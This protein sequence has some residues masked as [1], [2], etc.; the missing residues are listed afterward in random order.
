MSDKAIVI[1]VV[2]IGLFLW[3]RI[4]DAGQI[5]SSAV[6]SINPA[7]TENLIYKGA[8]RVYD[9]IAGVTDKPIGVA[10]WEALH[11]NRDAWLTAPYP[12]YMD[13]PAFGGP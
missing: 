2:L 12:S 1:G 7:S 10:V 3:Q 13:N 4:K 9:D 6:P 8:S 11:P 5:I